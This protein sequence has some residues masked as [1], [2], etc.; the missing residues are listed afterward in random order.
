MTK[1]TK[2][3]VVPIKE[4]PTIHVVDFE[5]LDEDNHLRKGEYLGDGCYAT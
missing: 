2:D 5:E 1:E 4:E 3:N